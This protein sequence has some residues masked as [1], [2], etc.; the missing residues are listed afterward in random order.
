MRF[1]EEKV[2]L[3]GDFEATFTQVATP[4]EDQA[5]LR[6]L[7]VQSPEL[8]TEVYQYVRHI[9]GAKCAPTCLTILC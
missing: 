3:S 5:S 6:F 9:F 8:P 1:Q 2:V 4:E 7:M